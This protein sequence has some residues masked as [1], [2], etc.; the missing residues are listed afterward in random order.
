VFPVFVISD[1]PTMERFIL[2]QLA[3][4]FHEGRCR[5]TG[6][7]NDYLLRLIVLL[8]FSALL[9]IFPSQFSLLITV[10]MGSG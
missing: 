2:D 4:S 10:T 5:W 8:P 6:L 9:K 1:S 3:Y 7:R